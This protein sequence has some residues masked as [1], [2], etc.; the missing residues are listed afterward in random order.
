MNSEAVPPLFLGDG[1]LIGVGKEMATGGEGVVYAVGSDLVAKLYH[2]P[3][4]GQKV[5]KLE[6]MAQSSTPRL[7][8]VTAWPQGVLYDAQEQP[9]GFLMRRVNRHSDLHVLYGPKTRLLHYPDATYAFLVHVAANLARAFAVVHDHGHVVGDVNQGGV[10]VAKDGTVALV[11]CDSFQV[12]SGGVVYGCDVGVPH[13]QPPEL[14]NT[15][16]FRGLPRTVEHDRFGLAVLIFQTLFLARHPFAGRWDG[17]GEMGLERAIAERR[18]VYGKNAAQQQ[19]HAPPGSLPLRTVSDE[20]GALFERAFTASAE[21]RPTAREW[22]AGCDRFGGELRTCSS[23]AAHAHASL[24]AACP[25]CALENRAGISLFHAPEQAAAAGPDV[26]ALTAELGALQAALHVP[27]P[28]ALRALAPAAS[29]MA[30]GDDRLAAAHMLLNALDEQLTRANDACE[31]WPAR[32]QNWEVVRGIGVAVAGGLSAATAAL[33]VSLAPVAVA[34]AAVA[35]VAAVSVVASKPGTLK[36]LEA[37]RGRLRQARATAAASLAS[38]QAKVNAARAAANELWRLRSEAQAIIDALE[39]IREET[40]LKALLAQ[41]EASHLK[42]TEGCAEEAA[43]A[44]ARFNRDVESQQLR[45]HLDRFIIEDDGPR[46]VTKRTSTLLMA[47]GIESAF[48]LETTSLARLVPEAVAQELLAWRRSLI[49]AWKP[50]PRDPALLK[51][52]NELKRDLETKAVRQAL[53]LQTTLSALR[54]H[55]DKVGGTIEE[56]LRDLRRLTT[57]AE[58]IARSFP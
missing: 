9:R 31:A 48:D 13:Y 16:S 41:A 51:A 18:F 3:P 28:L 52:R 50:N 8:K 55:A 5:A 49:A 22:M 39:V 35:A 57:E 34:T 1:A 56:G 30:V 19:M 38:S 25:L 17:S 42:V 15:T 24:V 14:Q 53:T 27:G 10:A 33:A 29:F 26:D 58:D 4:D 47:A 45:A 2:Q 32:R 7:T 46:S 37:E 20:L 43:A 40:T 44:L 36:E 12:V 23:N 54:V 11:D 21:Q 6:A